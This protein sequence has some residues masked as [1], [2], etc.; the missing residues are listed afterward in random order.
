MVAEGFKWGG[1]I[2]GRQKDFMH[3]SLSGK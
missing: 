2:E 1:E 3:F